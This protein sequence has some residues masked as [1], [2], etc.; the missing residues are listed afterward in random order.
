MFWLH[1]I[2]QVK[3]DNIYS[4]H[5]SVLICYPFCMTAACC[6][7]MQRVLFYPFLHCRVTIA[8]GCDPCDYSFFIKYKCD[9]FKFNII[10]FFGPVALRFLSAVQLGVLWSIIM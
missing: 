5:Y 7:H 9:A 2:I 3:C 6:L 8:L 1:K 4:Y 10:F